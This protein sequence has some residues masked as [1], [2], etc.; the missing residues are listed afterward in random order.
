[1]RTCQVHGCKEPLSKPEHDLCLRHWKSSRDGKLDQCAECGTLAEP[2]LPHC[3]KCGPQREGARGGEYLSSTKIGKHLSLSAQQVNLVLAELGWIEKGPANKGWVPSGQGTRRDAVLRH[4]RETGI[5]YVVWPP[6]IVSDKVLLGALEELRAPSPATVAEAA[7]EQERSFGDKRPA[8]HGTLRAA[9]G[10]LV[11]SRGELVI[12]NWLY[13][14]G[15]LHAYERRLPIED[16]AYCD[17]WIPDGKVYIEYWGLDG[18][19]GYDAR[20]ERKL[21][22]YRKNG[23]DLI[24]VSNE[25]IEH[26]DDVLPPKLLRYKISSK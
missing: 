19:P 21:G 9:D 5:P 8:Q 24:E 20:R 26:L 15:I 17:F 16:E 14:A 6:R 11:R 2:G 22:L 10:H 4:A 3:P 18:D 12:D 7:A 13:M 1:M 25:D 23:L